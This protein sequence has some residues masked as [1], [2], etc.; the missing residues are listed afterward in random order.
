MAVFL[1]LKPCCNVT[2]YDDLSVFVP[3]EEF[4][5][6]SGKHSLRMHFD[7]HYENGELFQHLT[8]YNFEFFRK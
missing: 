7:L 6:H 1:D 5:L 4:V 3:Y 8:Y 2:I